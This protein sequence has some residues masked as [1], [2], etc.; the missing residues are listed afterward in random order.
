MLV[1]KIILIVICILKIITSKSEIDAL[2]SKMDGFERPSLNRDIH[3]T[4][5][6]MCLCSCSIGAL[7]MTML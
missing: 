7:L 4:I 1:I 5:L 2:I 3:Y 6:G